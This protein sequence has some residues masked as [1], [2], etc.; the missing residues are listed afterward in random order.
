MVSPQPSDEQ[1]LFRAGNSPVA[2]LFIVFHPAC[3]FN[4]TR[5]VEEMGAWPQNHRH[6]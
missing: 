3:R 5:L 4:R 1:G 2:I 6:L